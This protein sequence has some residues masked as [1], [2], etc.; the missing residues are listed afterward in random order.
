M[1]PESTSMLGTS[2]IQQDFEGI[3][4]Q[5]KG[6]LGL[7]AHSEFSFRSKLRHSLPDFGNIFR[8][9]WACKKTGSNPGMGIRREWSFDEGIPYETGPTKRPPPVR[10]RLESFANASRVSAGKAQRT[11]VC[12]VPKTDGTA[13][14]SASFEPR[15]P[16]LPLRESILQIVLRR[17]DSCLGMRFPDTENLPVSLLSDLYVG[18]KI[19]TSRILAQH[20]HPKS[21]GIEVR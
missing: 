14:E 5:V 1:D 13:K 11:W 20:D 9:F 2:G 10:D 4:E 21:C 3:F 7:P 18:I 6:F 19:K 16:S 8:V 17:R 15:L 12:A